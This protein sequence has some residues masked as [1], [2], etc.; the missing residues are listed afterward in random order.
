MITVTLQCS[1][2]PKYEGK[3]PPRNTQL[4]PMGCPY[5]HDLYVIRQNK[6]VSLSHIAFRIRLLK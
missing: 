6:K 2:H 1:T 4:F 5:C 3:R